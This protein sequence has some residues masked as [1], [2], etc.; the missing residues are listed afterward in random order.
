[1]TVAKS[2]INSELKKHINFFYDLFDFIGKYWYVLITFFLSLLIVSLFTFT[3]S[4]RIL[5]YSSANLLNS[6]NLVQDYIWVANPVNFNS[7]VRGLTAKYILTPTFIKHISIYLGQGVFMDNNGFYYPNGVTFPITYL[8]KSDLW[9]KKNLYR[10]YYVLQRLKL[11]NYSPVKIRSSKWL[12]VSE[13]KNRYNLYCIDSFLNDSLFCN[14]NKFLLI[15]QIEKGS[16]EL[17]KSAYSYL[18]ANLFLTSSV[19]CNILK[20][21]FSKT[22]NYSNISSVVKT[23][24]STNEAYNFKSSFEVAKIGRNIF[25]SDIPTTY[26]AKMTKLANQW[27]YFVDHKKLPNENI[28]SHIQFVTKLLANWLIAQ[29]EAVIE[30]NI[31]NTIKVKI[32]SNIDSDLLVK[33]L[34]LLIS[35]NPIAG[36]KW[37]KSIAGNVKLISAN[38]LVMYEP[39][40]IKSVRERFLYL[41]NSKYANIFILSKKVVFD[42]KSNLALLEGYLKLSVLGEGKSRVHK[43]LLVRFSVPLDSFLWSKFLIKDLQILDTWVVQYLNTN[44]ISYPKSGYLVDI[45]NRLKLLLGNYILNGKSVAL[46]FCDIATQKLKSVSC[47]GY[48]LKLVDNEIPGLSIYYSFNKDQTLATVSL[49]KTVKVP[50]V[51]WWS[52]IP[53]FITVPLDKL[54]LKLNKLISRTNYSLKDV[55]LIKSLIVKYIRKYAENYK[56]RLIGISASDLVKI[57]TLLKQYLNSDLVYVEHIKDSFYN[58][59]FT[60]KGYEFEGIYNL[61]KNKFY[62]LFLV[63]PD[64]WKKFGFNVHLALSDL[65][66]EK[67]N[68]FKSNPLDYLSKINATEV[69]QYKSL[70]KHVHK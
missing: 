6:S 19:K 65:N 25:S 34:N 2:F 13:L 3:N 17:S 31:I 30:L 59:Y 29:R 28:L 55:P 15:R 7:K 1:M 9:F 57:S 63:L 40:V 33:K 46:S 62:K 60:L 49:P 39:T 26:D 48:M 4:S 5:A 23:Y 70:V 67:L 41:L 37:L 42:S 64:Q 68:D 69:Q 21:I 16:I 20:K 12:S 14:A 58:I 10:Y 56:L 54:T 44:N 53:T 8:P 11:F 18:F 47:S 36:L 32:S 24:C 61:D 22:Y 35:W 52:T 66:L 43:K 51:K 38:N 50:M 27:L 45:Y